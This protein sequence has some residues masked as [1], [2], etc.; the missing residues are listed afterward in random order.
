MIL[1]RQI[2]KS[3]KGKVNKENRSCRQEKNNL[4]RNISA[5]SN[6]NGK[7]KLLSSRLAF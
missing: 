7:P 3:N 4:T 2:I 5:A 6:D 1:R